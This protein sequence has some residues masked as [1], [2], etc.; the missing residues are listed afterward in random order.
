VTG[1]DATDDVSDTCSVTSSTLSD[2]RS[3]GGSAAS[4]LDRCVCAGTRCCLVRNRS[5]GAPSTCLLPPSQ[6][7]FSNG[8]QGNEHSSLTGGLSS[9]SQMQRGG[10]NDRLPSTKGGGRIDLMKMRMKYMNKAGGAGAGE[11]VDEGLTSV[12]AKQVRHKRRT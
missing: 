4:S 10:L 9:L 8:R 12:Y 6:L 2:A 3:H 11:E 1:D 7:K 5:P